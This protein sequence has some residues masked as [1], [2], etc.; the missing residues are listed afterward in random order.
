MNKEIIENL[1][2]S[3]MEEVK[4]GQAYVEI[5][6]DLNINVAT[7][8]SFIFQIV[9]QSSKSITFMGGILVFPEQL[10][11]FSNQKRI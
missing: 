6:K 7:L 8:K 5:G 3:E 1:L 10:L 4:G 11:I 2:L 9:E